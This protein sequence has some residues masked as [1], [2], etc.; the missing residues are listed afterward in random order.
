MDKATALII[1]SLERAEAAFAEL[2]SLEGKL[3]LIELDLNEKLEAARA[4]ALEEST[5]L[6]KRHKELV[7]SLKSYGKRQQSVIFKDRQSHVFAFGT[8][9]RRES[10]K[11]IQMNGT[12][13]AFTLKKLKELDLREGIKTTEELAKENM[14]KWPVERLELVG[15]R[16]QK[17][18][19][20]HVDVN[21]EKVKTR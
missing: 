6:G 1:D 21:K 17:S 7:A 14:E 18:T 10:G 5:P 15:L 19:S 20:Y 3:G 4:S 8:L 16:W 9:A 13:K 12:D 2:A 11:L